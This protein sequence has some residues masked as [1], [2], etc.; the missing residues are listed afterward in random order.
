MQFP[1]IPRQEQHL[2]VMLGNVL[3]L[4]PGVLHVMLGFDQP[5]HGRLA[6]HMLHAHHEVREKVVPML[7]ANQLNRIGF[8]IRVA[9]PPGDKAGPIQRI[10]KRSFVAVQGER[11]IKIRIPIKMWLIEL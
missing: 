7:A 3:G 6:V 9:E 4:S 8:P 10:G 5:G 1:A 2:S 11:G